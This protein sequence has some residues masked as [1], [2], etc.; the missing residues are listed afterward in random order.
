M[1]RAAEKRITGADLVR[2]DEDAQP[3]TSEP[4]RAIE[5]SGVAALRRTFGAERV[6][7]QEVLAPYTTFRV[8]GPA[9]FFFEAR[10]ADELSDAIRLCRQHEITHFLLGMGANILIGDRG[11]RGLVIRN[12][13]RRMKRLG[14]TRIYAESGVIVYPDLI[15]MT[16]Q[17]GLSGLE[18]YVGIPSTVGGAVW[19]NLH[20]LSPPPERERTMFIE[21]VLEEAE[22]LSA[23]GHRRRV[24]VDYFEFGYDYSILHVRE[25]V[26]LAATFRLE[27]AEVEHLR[28]VMSENLAWRAERHP[29]LATEP[30]A[31]SIFKK[32]EGIG[33]GRLI[34]AA[35]LK[36]TYIGGAQVTHRH[37]NIMINRGGATAADICALIAYVQ[38][39]VER[40][41]GLRLEP[42]ISFVGEFDPPST[43]E[44]Q[45]LEAPGIP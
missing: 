26:V 10:S 22:I 25:D 23:E 30:S 34:D 38:D 32:I 12:L 2:R 27:P 13:A 37:A 14:S 4:T 6:R 16:V 44:P 20:F 29:P 3:G 35:G 31:G 28:W 39:V 41:S 15:E 33:A 21:E 7:E 9:D 42:E 19:Q 17:A 11:F 40:D 8:G 18:H 24:G 43:T 5:P 1:R 36:G 45:R